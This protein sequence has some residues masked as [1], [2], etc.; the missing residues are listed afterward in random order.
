MPRIKV[1]QAIRQ[2]AIGG[3]ESH[4]LDLVEHLDKKVYEPIVLAFTEG[5]MIERL[6]QMGVQT[7]VIP[8]TRPFDFT[9][10]GRVS[11]LLE[12]EKIELI[13]IH[14]TRANTNL[15]FPGQW[16][17]LPMIY[18]V[19]GW[20]FHDDLPPFKRKLRIWSE[21]MMTRRMA[22][23]ITV[24]EANKRS[25][26]ELIPGFRTE[27]VHYG[28][29]LKRFD[30][31][32]SLANLRAELGIGQ[33]EFLLGYIAR[34]TKQKA[35]L[36]MLR[37]FRL[38]LDQLGSNAKLKLLLV[39]EGEMKAEMLALAKELNLEPHLVIQPFRTDVPEVL[40]AIDAYCL[41]S[42]WEGLPI[43]L[44]EA[45]AM[46]KPVIASRVDGTANILHDREN[47][48]LIAP[49]KPQELA[50]AIVALYQ[51][52][53][54]RE[55]VARGAHQTILAHYSAE[56]MARQVETVYQNALQVPQKQ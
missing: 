56:R 27:V 41:P 23:T 5:A 42:L 10:W 12:K 6:K 55:R 17:H 53:D 37:G 18:T 51:D 46:R 47:G 21:A 52:A 30:P 13:H 32:R 25:G 38:A 15:V 43:G 44:L 28:I 2:G 29:N 14:G 54:L 45:M 8:T 11:A 40:A 48:L 16:N 39:G 26:E 34:I 36:D 19:H 33:D 20:S 7:H 49:Q 31:A 35:P 22:T 3:G 50:S 1:L 24:S 9:V 4:V